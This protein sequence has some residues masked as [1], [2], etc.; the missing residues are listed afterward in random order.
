MQHINISPERLKE[1]EAEAKR[2]ILARQSTVSLVESKLYTTKIILS[3]LVFKVFLIEG[4]E[5]IEVV[6][7]YLTDVLRHRSTALDTETY[8]DSVALQQHEAFIRTLPISDKEK[9]SYIKSVKK[10]AALRP[11]FTKLRFI[12]LCN[13]STRQL[14]VIDW[15][16]ISEA[17]KLAIQETLNQSVTTFWAHNMLYDYMVLSKHGIFLQS[18]KC[19]LLA[20]IMTNFSRGVEQNGLKEIAK[21]LLNDTLKDEGGTTDFSNQNLSDD[22]YDY[23]YKD[24]AAVALLIPIMEEK[25]KCLHNPALLGN[26]ANRAIDPFD[27]N[28]DCIKPF[29]EMQLTGLPTDLPCFLK[30]SANIKRKLERIKKPLINKMPKYEGTLLSTEHLRQYLTGKVSEHSAETLLDELE[31][32][33]KGQASFGKKSLKILLNKLPAEIKK[34]MKSWFHYIDLKSKNSNDG[35]GRLAQYSNCGNTLHSSYRILG[36]ST[37]RTTSSACN[38]QNMPRGKEG[39]RSMIKAPEGYVFVL[40]DFSQ[41]ELRVAAHGLNLPIMKG[42]FAEGADLHED[43]LNLLINKNGIPQL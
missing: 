38:L 7:K 24:G 11:Q 18:I 37:G 3:T 39:L 13:P 1:L 33:A 35:Y 12:T 4:N 41:Q 22:A 20:R 43:L 2:R 8:G 5:P 34:F 40:M 19:S 6:V 23:V 29:A 42:F 14:I 26:T 27:L 21:I 17:L 10:E 16:K 9:V 32:T 31:K 25:L 15:L 28:C 36:A 30:D